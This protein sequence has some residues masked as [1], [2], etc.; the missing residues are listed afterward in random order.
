LRTHPSHPPPQLLFNDAV[1][2]VRAGLPL[3]AP[4]AALAPYAALP[5]GA[6]LGNRDLDKALGSLGAAEYARMVGPSEQLSKGI[7][8]SYAAALHANLVCLVSSLGAGLEGKSV[9]AF[10]YGSGALA[11]MMALQG[12]ASSSASGGGFSLA[13]M[14][15]Q[16]RVAQRLQARSECT[17]AVYAE[18]M[19][20]RERAYGK[21]GFAPVGSCDTLAPGTFYLKEV[22]AAGVRSYGRA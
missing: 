4:L 15:A 5:H 11:T 9:G 21:L 10:S 3:P 16:L 22:S 1:R 18:A 19:G 20:L 2:A 6:T 7:G 12:R 8:N 14:A 17:P 13:A